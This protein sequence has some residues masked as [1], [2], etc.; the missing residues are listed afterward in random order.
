MIDG[1]KEKIAPYAISFLKAVQPEI[2]FAIEQS[3]IISLIIGRKLRNGR[4]K[5]A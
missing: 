4:T 2:A 5:K 3:V 1:I